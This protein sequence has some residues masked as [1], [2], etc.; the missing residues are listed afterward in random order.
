M[1]LYV[2]YT[3]P[4]ARMPRIVRQEKGLEG[5]VEV[6]AAKTRAEDSDYYRINPSGRVPYLVTDDGTGYEGS[7]LICQILDGLDGAQRFAAPTGPAA[8]EFLRL[9]EYARSFMDGV[10]VWVRETL[11]PE[12]DQSATVIAH[13]RARESRLADF[14]EAAIDHPV[15]NGDFNRVQLTLGCGLLTDQRF[16]DMQWRTGRPKLVQ[17]A[18]KIAARPSFVETHPD[19]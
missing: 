2:T 8:I 1:K 3:S 12:A 4:Y 7:A 15:L 17:W 18:E 13:E 16:P 14:W 10:S 11:R 9:E 5:Q 6:V 19:Q